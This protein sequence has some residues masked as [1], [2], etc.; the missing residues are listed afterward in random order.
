MS[1]AKKE[2]GEPMRT[3]KG[4]KSTDNPLYNSSDPVYEEIKDGNTMEKNEREVVNKRQLTD[5]LIKRNKYVNNEITVQNRNL[6][7]DIAKCPNTSGTYENTKPMN[8]Y[9]KCQH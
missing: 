1:F 2:P 5:V 6:E 8:T 7:N 9:A 3:L 4:V